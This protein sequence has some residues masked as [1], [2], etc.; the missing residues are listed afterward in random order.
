MIDHLNILKVD[1]QITQVYKS[2]LTLF[3]LSSN[4][5]KYFDGETFHVYNSKAY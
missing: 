4:F 1:I 5:K 3:S 2:W